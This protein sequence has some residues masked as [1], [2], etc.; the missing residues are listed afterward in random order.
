MLMSLEA[1]FQPGDNYAPYPLVAAGIIFIFTLQDLE[2]STLPWVQNLPGEGQQ[3][4]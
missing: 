1:N 4:S 3:R 2:S